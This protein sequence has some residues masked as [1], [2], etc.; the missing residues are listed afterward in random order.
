MANIDY[1][2]WMSADL[3]AGKVDTGTT[4]I[5]MRSVQATPASATSTRYYVDFGRVGGA[6]AG[7]CLKKANGKVFDIK[8]KAR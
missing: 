6:S 5:G 8:G 4:A 1:I 3:Y 7:V 2:G